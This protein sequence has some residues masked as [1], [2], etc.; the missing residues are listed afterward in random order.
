MRGA[1]VSASLLLYFGVWGLLTP[2][3]LAPD[4]A[5]H[6]VKAL[7]VP[8]NPWV[9][10]SP[11]VE[12][13]NTRLNPLLLLPYVRTIQG[14]PQRKLSAAYVE[15]LKRAAWRPDSEGASR[16]PTAAH[17]YPPLYYA[18]VLALGEGVTALLSLSPYASI[19]AFRAG[20]AVLAA[21]LWTI[22]FARLGFLGRLRTEVF[23]LVL[24]VPMVGILSSSINPDAVFI[25]LC[26]LFMI[27]SYEVIFQGRSLLTAA[28]LLLALTFTKSAAALLIFPTLAVLVATAWLV[29]RIRGDAR[30]DWRNAAVLIGGVLIVFYAAFYHWSP[31]YPAETFPEKFHKRLVDYLLEVGVHGRVLFASFWLALGLPDTLAPSFAYRILFIVIALNAAVFAWRFRGLEEK[32]RFWFLIGFALL[33][34]VALLAGEYVNFAKTAYILQGRYFLP[35]ALG[36]L[37]VTCHGVRVLRRAFIVV[38]VAFNLYAMHLS[39]V[40]YYAGDWSAIWRALPFAA[41]PRS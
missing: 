9:A 36:F 23:A 1:L 8:S 2:P 6:L 24:L 32:G 29:G 33:Y 37:L 31:V 30:I 12:I 18:V 4:E 13:R 34:S 26:T 16:L 14:S 7:S 28:A 19:Y 5:T 27:S 40:R 39:T 15:R 22:V 10:R 20:S 41:S 3:L 35:V 11:Q 25:P 38:L 21:G 17:I